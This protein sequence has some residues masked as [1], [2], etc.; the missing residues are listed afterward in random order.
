MLV[1]AQLLQRTAGDEKSSGV[2]SGPVGKTMFDTVG[3]ELVGVRGTEYFVTGDLG[4]DNLADDITVGEAN[5]E[6]VLWCVVLVLGL[7]D[8]ALSCIVVGLSCPTALV[9]SL[10]A[11]AMTLFEVHPYHSSHGYSPI[12]RAVL[13]QLCERL[14]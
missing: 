4:G 14:H 6:A 10:I 5:N 8:E 11:T 9:L 1:Q 3:F 2:C 12:I 13:D 7:G